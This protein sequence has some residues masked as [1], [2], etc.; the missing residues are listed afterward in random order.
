MAEGRVDSI[1]NTPITRRGFLKGAVGLA[2]GGTLL[3]HGVEA[4]TP[5]PM[6]GIEWNST[7]PT[8]KSSTEADVAQYRKEL[9]K[10][11]RSN[12]ETFMSP[13]NDNL[14][15]VQ[16]EALKMHVDIPTYGSVSTP[17][18]DLNPEDTQSH[19]RYFISERNQPDKF[20]PNIGLGEIKSNAE[21]DRKYELQMSGG[22]YMGR[23]EAVDDEGNINNI[24]YYGLTMGDSKGG[25]VPLTKV[26]LP[27]NFG[28]IKPD[29]GM[30]QDIRYGLRN[31]SGNYVG[32]VNA[33]SGQT[34][35]YLADMLGL[36]D[37]NIGALHLLQI[38]FTANQPGIADLAAQLNY[39]VKYYQPEWLA[40]ESDNTLQIGYT[41]QDLVMKT[42]NDQNFELNSI[43]GSTP[44]PTPIAAA[45]PEAVNVN[46]DTAVGKL[47][48]YRHYLSSGHLQ[49]GDGEIIDLPRARE[50]LITP[51]SLMESVQV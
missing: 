8:L 1:L 24:G 6:Q 30:S 36:V 26:I 39:P 18:V 40:A 32:V 19:A 34:L 7:V 5:V 16:G 44:T 48:D 17:F 42:A 37:Q 50:V 12:I 31:D 14:L 3:P 47:P 29:R 2:A 22:F 9:R 15:Q 46:V 20:F 25:T 4:R 49:L 33:G 11:V 45:S 13:Q 21:G 23:S 38:N 28:W 51:L 27:I 35:T 10:V 41:L 43:V